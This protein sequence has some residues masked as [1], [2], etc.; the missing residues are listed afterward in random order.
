[1]INT[2]Y[3]ILSPEK[4]MFMLDID[5]ILANIL[6]LKKEEKLYLVEQILTSLH[7]VNKGV[8]A[9]WAEEAEERVKAFESGNVHEVNLQDA[10]AKYDK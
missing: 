6:V 5:K 9:A 4:R 7:P 1:M 8:D 3:D 2:R 10:F